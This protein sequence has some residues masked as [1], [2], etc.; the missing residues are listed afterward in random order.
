[1]IQATN[2]LTHIIQNPQKCKSLNYVYCLYLKV[3][4][5]YKII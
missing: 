1:M 5:V 2:M 4:Y 3:Q